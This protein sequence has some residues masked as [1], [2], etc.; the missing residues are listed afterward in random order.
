MYRQCEKLIIKSKAIATKY[1]NHLQLLELLNWENKL[2]GALEFQ[3]KE[4]IPMESNYRN[5]YSILDQYRNCQKYEYLLFKFRFIGLKVGG[6]RSHKDIALREKIINHPL[7]GSEDKALSFSAKIY[8]YICHI[9]FLSAKGDH[10]NSKLY[11]EKEIKLIESNFHQAEENPRIYIRALNGL[12]INLSKLNKY[13][14]ALSAINTMENLSMLP[15]SLKLK[16]LIQTY[17]MKINICLA[18]GAFEKGLELIQN[19][20]VYQQYKDKNS[21]DLLLIY[22]ISYIYLGNGDFANANIWLNRIINDD[23]TLRPDL[24]CFSRILSLIVHFE[25]GKD[26]SLEY[27]I[28]ST[29]SFLY[30]KKGLFKVESAILDFLENKIAKIKS[31]KDLIAAFRALRAELIKISKIAYEK[32]AFDYFDFISWLTSKIEN[33]SFAKVVQEKL[34][35][36]S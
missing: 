22:N 15:S 3:K 10:I 7:F 35:L 19:D 18:T 33:R 5:I 13:D 36:N 23:T 12:I 17:N 25:L 21:L 6:H 34:A 27:A 30:K 11:S 20:T 14:E 16:T 32:R 2:I 1:D 4:I 29:Y 24:Q 8:F 9:G 28:K 26:G 31:N